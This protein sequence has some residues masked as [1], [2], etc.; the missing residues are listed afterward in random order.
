MTFAE[1]IRAPRNVIRGLFKL[2]R[3]VF[4]FAEER[5]NRVVRFLLIIKAYKAGEKIDAIAHRYKCSKSTIHRNI[6]IAGI[7]RRGQ[8]KKNVNDAVLEDYKSGIPIAEIA[9]K[10]GVSQAF[11]SR[12]ATRA[13]INRRKFK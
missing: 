8:R 5:S 7:E 9:K 6:R 1:A 11:V 10:H 3:R 12:E 2:V 13:G 4:D